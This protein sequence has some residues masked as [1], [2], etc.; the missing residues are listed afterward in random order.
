MTDM[1]S[2]EIM[3]EIDRA[4]KMIA[5]RFSKTEN[6]DIPVSE[7]NPGSRPERTLLVLASD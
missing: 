5:A 2:E 3:D 7:P 1:T 4:M 6:P